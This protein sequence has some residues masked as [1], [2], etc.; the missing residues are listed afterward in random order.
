MELP[1]SIR[2]MSCSTQCSTTRRSEDNATVGRSRLRPVSDTDSSDAING[3][4]ETTAYTLILPP[5]PPPSLLLLPFHASQYR[6]LPAC[7]AVLVVAAEC[8][9]AKRLLPAGDKLFNCLPH[10][11]STYDKNEAS[12]TATTKIVY[13]WHS[14]AGTK[15]YTRNSKTRTALNRQAN[16]DVYIH[17]TS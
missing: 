14:A 15:T 9:A 2:T 5:P 17:V 16:V 8:A 10:N 13:I 3:R 1:D 12:S 6:R 7:S 11:Q 4:R